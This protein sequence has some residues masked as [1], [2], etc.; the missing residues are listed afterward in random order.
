ML[1][2]R[3]FHLALVFFLVL[4]LPSPGGARESANDE[5]QVREFLG[6]FIAAFNNLNWEQFRNC[7]DDEAT[8]IHPAHFP[9]RLDGRASFEPSWQAIFGDIR[10]SS[11][12]S[13]PPFMNLKPDDMKL[14]MLPGAA[15][16]TFHLH[17]A[18]KSV[19][20]RTLVVRRTRSGWKIIHLH[21]SNADF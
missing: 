18:G 2:I 12:R 8:V 6:R 16:I 20:R 9:E 21:A 17:R 7:F 10:S 3:R 1:K 11:G 14:Q 13:Q 19:G 4:I 5:S 15:V